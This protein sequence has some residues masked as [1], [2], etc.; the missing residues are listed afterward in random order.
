MENFEAYVTATFEFTKELEAFRKKPTAASA[1][2]LRKHMQDAAS[3]KVEAK[4][5]LMEVGK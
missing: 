3:A 5:E 4:R 2:R 1:K